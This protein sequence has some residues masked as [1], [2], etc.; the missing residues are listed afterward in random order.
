M[1]V[2]P[3]DTDPASSGSTRRPVLDHA[4][5]DVPRLRAAMARGLVQGIEREQL[6]ELGLTDDRLIAV[7]ISLGMPRWSA[8]QMRSNPMLRLCYLRTFWDVQEAAGGD[9]E[10]RERVDAIRAHFVEAR[11]LELVSD[12]P[13]HTI[14]LWER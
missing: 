11:A 9:A 14:G 1:S 8:E 13:G 3:Y 12:R 6:L 5:F 10:A 4:V 2:R 7:V